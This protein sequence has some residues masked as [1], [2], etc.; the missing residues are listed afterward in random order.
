MNRFVTWSGSRLALPLL[1]ALAAVLPL[2]RAAAEDVVDPVDAIEDQ[3]L[4]EESRQSVE[5]PMLGKGVRYGLG[6]IVL[7]T[8]LGV[9]Y[10]HSGFFPGYCAEAYWFPELRVALALQINSSDFANLGGPPREM[11]VRLEPP[12]YE[13]L[14]QPSYQG[15]RGDLT[16]DDLR[17]S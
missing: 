17:G 10:G 7:E 9:A 8:P 6:V 15:L 3:A 14:R 1:A 4:L 5:A 11:L 12:G 13:R 16:V 2:S